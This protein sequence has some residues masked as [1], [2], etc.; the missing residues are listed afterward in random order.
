[1][2]EELV[3]HPQHYGGDAVNEVIKVLEVW[4]TPEEFIG[5]LGNFMKA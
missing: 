2:A 1:M 3:N 4:L 5:V